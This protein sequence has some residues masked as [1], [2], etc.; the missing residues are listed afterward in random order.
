MMIIMIIKIVHSLK[1]FKKKKKYNM[2][3][4]REIHKIKGLD[5]VA[6]SVNNDNNK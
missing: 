6:T 2:K 5:L 3:R 1:I 4:E